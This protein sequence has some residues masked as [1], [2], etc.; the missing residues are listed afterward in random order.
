MRSRAY[1][2]HSSKAV[3]AQQPSLDLATKNLL[4]PLWDGRQGGFVERVEHR[5]AH[6]VGIGLTL[7]AC[8]ILRSYG[9][10][11]YV[12]FRTVVKMGVMST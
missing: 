4:D 1:D 8:L 11:D 3:I 2:S 6:V 5:A 10:E 7:S 9:C 12:S